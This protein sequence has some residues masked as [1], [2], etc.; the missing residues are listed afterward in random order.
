M[1][2][3][4]RPSRVPVR[5]A[6]HRRRPGAAGRLGRAWRLGGHGR[7]RG[8][9]PHR[10]VA[11]SRCA[12]TGRWRWRSV[13]RR[14][15]A[16]RA[17]A[18]RPVDLPGRVHPAPRRCPGGHPRRRCPV[19]H[20]HPSRP[21]RPDVPRARGRIQAVGARLP[22]AGP[23]PAARSPDSWGRARRGDRHR[24]M[25]ALPRRIG[26]HV[27]GIAALHHPERRRL[28]AARPRRT[29]RGHP[30][31]GSARAT[32]PRVARRRGLH[33]SPSMAGGAPG[34]RVG[35]THPRSRHPPLLRG[36]PRGLRARLGADH[37]ALDGPAG[38]RG[39][40][41]G[42][43]RAPLPAPV[44]CSPRRPAPGD[45]PRP[46]RRRPG[47]RPRRRR[48]PAGSAGRARVVR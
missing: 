35:P 33:P 32:R 27:D 19:G 1:E 43:A 25:G 10:P 11:G 37:R 13:R 15:S 23:G 41:G 46:A 2:R 16:R 47:G 39:H 30:G 18:C 48:C 34:R 22:P 40:R 28:R 9:G 38:Q 12:I 36:R 17:H 24:A 8:A 45:L 31:M 6:E 42:V 26:W 21:A 44:R 7:H 4:R 20:R 5:A 14:R 3:L 29:R